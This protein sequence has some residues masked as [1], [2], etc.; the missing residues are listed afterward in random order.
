MSGSKR[1]SCVVCAWRESCAKKFCVTDGGAHC[2]DYTRDIAIKDPE[3]GS[4]DTE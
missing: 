2:P 3:D 4:E 1:Q